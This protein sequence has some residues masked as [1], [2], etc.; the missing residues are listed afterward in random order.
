ME[1]EMTFT[2]TVEDTNFCTTKT[3]S[4]RCRDGAEMATLIRHQWRHGSVDYELNFEDAYCGGDYTGIWGRIK[5][6]WR[7]LCDKPICYTGL[8]FEGSPRIRRFL[9]DCL[10]MVNETCPV[11]EQ[12]VEEETQ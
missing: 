4:V 11:P 2:S 7:A 3:V 12:E 1:D 6:A 8:Y 5:R 10:A 9:V